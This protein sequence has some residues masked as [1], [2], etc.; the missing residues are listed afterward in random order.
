MR[1]LWAPFVC[2]RN[3]QSTAQNRQTPSSGPCQPSGGRETLLL[4]LHITTIDYSRFL[5]E[6]TPGLEFLR[7]LRG[8][9]EVQW[10]GK[11]SHLWNAH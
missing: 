11:T 3:G 7:Q 4:L 10:E 5:P 1:A 2:L 8:R 6:F 9:H